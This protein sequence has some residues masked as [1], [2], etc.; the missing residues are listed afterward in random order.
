MPS[1]DGTV[2]CDRHQSVAIAR[3]VTKRTTGEVMP[4]IEVLEFES[5]RRSEIA[6]QQCEDDVF[7][8]ERCSSSE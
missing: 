1:R 4:E 5:G 6:G 3:I 7:R 2:D 8:S